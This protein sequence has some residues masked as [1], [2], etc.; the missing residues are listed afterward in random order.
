MLV[1]TWVFN[2]CDNIYYN[3]SYSRIPFN[4]CSDSKLFQFMDTIVYLS[5]VFSLL[6]EAEGRS[7]HK[8]ESA[9]GGTQDI[10]WR[11]GNDNPLYGYISSS[12]PLCS[13]HLMLTQNFFIFCLFSSLKTYNNWVLIF[14]IGLKCIWLIDHHLLV[15]MKECNGIIIYHKIIYT[16]AGLCNVC[17][18]GMLHETSVV[19][20]NDMQWNS[21]LTDIMYS[22]SDFVIIISLS[23][24]SILSFSL[25]STSI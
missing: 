4:N 22:H 21:G 14:I 10:N 7:V 16:T 1:Y 24:L 13:F 3:C 9:H 5:W 25:V 8:H 23:I 15:V 12:T 20:Y 19:Y 6:V 18:R 2:S 17:E 11:T